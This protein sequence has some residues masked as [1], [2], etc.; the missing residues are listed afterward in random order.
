MTDIKVKTAGLSVSSDGSSSGILESGSVSGG[1]NDLTMSA[2]DDSVS[3]TA[4]ATATAVTAAALNEEWRVKYEH[5]YESHRK[6]QKMN[7]ALED[8]LLRVVDKFEGE[9]NQMSRDL[10]QQTQKL[11]QAKL[12][13]QQLHEQNQDLESDLHL[14]INLLRNN[15]PSNFMSKK[16]DAL[17]ADMRPRV[18]SCIAEQKAAEQRQQR[19]KAEGRKITVAVEPTAKE[20]VNATTSEDED[21]VSAAILAKVLEERDKERRREN[22]F[23]IDVGTQTHGW[24]FPTPTPNGQDK[25]HLHQKDTSGSSASSTLS[26]PVK[27]SEFS[28]LHL[29]SVIL[30]P[31]PDIKR[32]SF[33]SS[34]SMAGVSASAASSYLTRSATFSAMQT[35]I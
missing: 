11:V 5:L 34:L 32:Q 23:C 4:A 17:P 1:S 29:T 35:D 27:P 15:R 3:V 14:S 21:K 19:C 18:R 20:G 12:T 7:S 33:K 9:K 28:G 2:G 16:V 24:H 10:A 30:P 31:P 26:S 6:L 22:K 8:K 13:I 25:R